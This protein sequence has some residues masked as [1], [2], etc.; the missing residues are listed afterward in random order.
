MKFIFRRPEA[1]S[2]SFVIDC[3][4]FGNRII[5]ERN[6]TFFL[7]FNYLVSKRCRDLCKG[8]SKIILGIHS[9]VKLLTNIL[10]RVYSK[11]TPSVKICFNSS[12][13]CAFDNLV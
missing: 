3:F 4:Y 9:K 2:R 1:F 7:R 13:D 12:Y 8:N 10:L 5:N 11:L 6:L